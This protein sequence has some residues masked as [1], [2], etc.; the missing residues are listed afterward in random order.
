MQLQADTSSSTS[1]SLY[2]TAQRSWQGKHH[3]SAGNVGQNCE[4]VSPSVRRVQVRDDAPSNR[5]VS[6]SLDRNRHGSWQVK[7]CNSDGFE[8]Q[9]H[10]HVTCGR[11]QGERHGSS[12]F[13]GRNPHGSWQVNGCNSDGFKPRNH[14]HVTSGRHQDEGHESSTFRGGNLC[15]EDGAKQWVMSSKAINSTADSSHDEKC[16]SMPFES[17]GPLHLDHSFIQSIDLPAE[18]TCQSVSHSGSEAIV[19]TD[20]EHTNENEGHV[21]CSTQVEAFDICPPKS[22]SLFTLKPSLFSKNREKRNEKKKSDGIILRPGMVLL[23]RYLS[24][25]EQVI[26][27]SCS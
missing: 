15:T 5:R 4:N 21:D 19:S 24:I 12:T 16:E 23:K 26:L 20:K 9:N 11:H 17:K 14:E 7:G 13:R 3:Y 6:S 18:V 2:R 1:G 8:P 10:E 27:F 22:D 25:S